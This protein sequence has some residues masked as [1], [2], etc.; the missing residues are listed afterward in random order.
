MKGDILSK[1]LMGISTFP[2]D[3]YFGSNFQEIIWAL[4]IYFIALID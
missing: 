4:S 3:H 1:K 2:N